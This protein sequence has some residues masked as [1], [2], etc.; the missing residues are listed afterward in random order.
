MHTFSDLV[1]CLDIDLFIRFLKYVL[2]LLMVFKF[3]LESLPQS[4]IDY[5]YNTFAYLCLYSNN[6]VHIC[7]FFSRYNVIQLFTILGAQFGSV[8]R[9][10]RIHYSHFSVSHCLC[11]SDIAFCPFLCDVGRT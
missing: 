9:V 1:S 6:E 7:V 11:F 4:E 3:V 2:V 8:F 10:S 5:S